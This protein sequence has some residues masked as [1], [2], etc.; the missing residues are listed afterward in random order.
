MFTKN[1]LAMAV[2]AALP[3]CAVAAEEIVAN[4]APVPA[5]QAAVPGASRTYA[6]ELVERTAARH[7]ELL[8]LDLHAAP[9]AG[10]PSVIIAAKDPARIGR[11]SDADDVEVSKTG[12]PFVE[13]NKAGDQNVEVHAPLLDV[14]RRIVGEVEM[15][16]PYPPGSGFDE[17]ALIKAGEHIRDEMARRILDLPSL[18]EPIQLDPKVPT[19]TYAQS[20]VDETLLRY[21]EVEVIAI[22]APV[23]G[24]EGY[25]VLASNIGRIGK[26]ADAGDLDVLGTGKPH[27]QTDPQGSRVEAKL[28]L[29]DVAGNRVGVLAVVYALRPLADE[30]GVLP[31]AERLRDDLR[32]RISGAA[33]LYEAKPVVPAPAATVV[34][35]EKLDEPALGNRQSLP[36]T[37]EVASAASLQNAQDGYSEAVKNQAGVAPAS[38]KGSP[39]DTISI[40]GINLNPISNYRINGGL[41]VAGVMTVPTEDKERLETLK[42]A[43]ALM[44]GIASPAGIINLVTKRA[45]NVDVST[46]SLAGTSFGQY[47]G[48]LDIGRRFGDEREFGARANLSATHLENGVHDASGHADFESLGADWKATDRLS[49]QGDVEHYRKHTILQGTVSILAPVNGVVPVPAVPNP[50]NLLSGTWATFDGETT[51]LQGRADFIIGEGWKAIAEIGRSDSDRTRYVTR[52]GKYNPDTGANGVVTTSFSDQNF[53]NEFKRV[54]LLG[55]FATWWLRHDLTVGVSESERDAFTPAQNS[56][57]LPQKQNIYDPVVLPPPVPTTPN[58]SLAPQI[59]KDTGLYTYDTVT[60]L[61]QAKALLGFRQTR[62]KQ[63][64]GLTKS[65]AIVNSPAGGFLYDV[66]PTTT[67]FASYMKGLE[68]GAIAPATAINANQIQPPGVSTQKEIG[69]RDSYFRGLSISASYFDISRV[70]AVTDAVTNIF[71]NNGRIHYKGGE[72]VIAWDINRQW[73]VNAA[74]QRLNAVQ[75]SDDPKINGLTPENTPKF[76]GNIFVTHRSPLLAGLTLSAGASYVK[77]RFVNPQDQGTIPG[78]T[79]YSASASYTTKIAGKRASFQLSIDN[80][81]NKRYWNSAQQGTYGTGMDRSFKLNAKFYF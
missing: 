68:D 37:K 65:S 18:T 1:L 36:M 4:P 77:E 27:V 48:A 23:P 16:F 71:S 5:A 75:L 7:P 19:G 47:Y 17:D 22:R 43:N 31:Q 44:F 21:P 50:R 32:G 60:L 62:S 67:L 49:L 12:V 74:G 30:A 8:H 41:A 3:A 61:P 55:S 11:P 33:A 76:I 25:P 63:D 24:V 56:I 53:V 15:T 29:Q 39:S 9:V 70:N 69:L 80:L 20:L 6:Q 28:P 72:A 14:D 54:E 78:Y 26:P 42:G 52:V 45:G 59:S 38:S 81:A 2:L 34:T 73:T 10:S 57:T 46:V 58:T 13:I 79:L 51:N 64:N 35:A 40:R 66:L